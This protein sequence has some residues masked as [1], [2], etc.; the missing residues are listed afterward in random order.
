MLRS[1]INAR[2]EEKSEVGDSILSVVMGNLMP[3]TEYLCSVKA[4]TVKG[5]GA[6]VT[7]RFFTLPQGEV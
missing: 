6:E 5:C 4:C 2:N 1:N 7:G 3:G